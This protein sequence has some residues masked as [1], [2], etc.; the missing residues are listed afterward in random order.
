MTTS[1]VSAI[2]RSVELTNKWLD[3]LTTQGDFH[4]R[5]QA[6][7]AFRAV[8]HAVRDRLI[9]DEA[10]DLASQLPMVVRG[11]YF[12]GWKP[13]LAPNKERTVQQF[14]DHVQSSLGRNVTID[15]KAATSAVLASL[16]RHVTEGQ[17]QHVRQMIPDEIIEELWPS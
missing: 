5:D 8:L 4:D 6:Y 12:E 7:S 2:E 15:P 13:S 14:L 16:D 17:V 10:V 3:E 11:F 9:V 1:T